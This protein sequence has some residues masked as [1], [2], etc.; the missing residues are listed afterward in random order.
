MGVGSVSGGFGGSY[1]NPLSSGPT[2]AQQ[3]QQV[4]QTQDR[5]R[6]QE[7]EAATQVQQEQVRQAGATTDTRGQRLNIVV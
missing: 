5:D 7:R 3:S 1:T 6:D 4:Q 2:A